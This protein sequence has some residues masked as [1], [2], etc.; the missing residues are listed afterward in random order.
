MR[1]I[2][3]VVREFLFLSLFVF[4]LFPI[5]NAIADPQ[6]E[7][8]ELVDSGLRLLEKDKKSKALEAFSQAIKLH[9]TASM[10]YVYRGRIHIE[11]KDL[12]AAGDD[13]NSALKNDSGNMSAYMERGNLYNASR[14]YKYAVNDY[15]VLIKRGTKEM[16]ALALGLRGNIYIEIDEQK[17]AIEDFTQLIELE[18]TKEVGYFGRAVVFDNMDDPLNA[19]EDYNRAIEINPLNVEALNR[20]AD[21][22]DYIG[23]RAS[24]RADRVRAR[25]ILN[26]S[27]DKKKKTGFN[28]VDSTWLSK[29]SA[30]ESSAIKSV[31][32]FRAALMFTNNPD[33]FF[34]QLK[35]GAYIA[36]ETEATRDKP[37]VAVL[38]FNGCLADRAGSCN[39]GVELEMFNPDGTLAVNFSENDLLI[40]GRDFTG[41]HT[42]VITI[43][44]AAEAGD[45][46]G[47]YQVKVKVI[48]ENGDKTLNL[49]QTF[50]LVGEAKATAKPVTKPK[51]EVAKAPAPTPS[52]PEESMKKAEEPVAPVAVESGW[53][54][55][56]RTTDGT[57]HS[58]DIAGIDK[59]TDS[60]RR[61]RVKKEMGEM[62]KGYMALYK[63]AL[64]KRG[65]DTDKFNYTIVKYEVDCSKNTLRTVGFSD[66][67]ATGEI[68]FERGSMESSPKTPKARSMDSIIVNY[69]CR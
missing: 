3:K 37:I 55:I 67:S 63:A 26:P 58:M 10:P 32:G 56:A 1:I 21:I 8:S 47:T 17:K 22:H 2:C 30:T 29:N 35:E 28:P 14:M 51:E 34:S 69:T 13:F 59:V 19:L 40:E 18:P 24:G 31:D 15:S 60:L 5:G 16:K 52:A 27:T 45:P 54:H 50:D 49:E 11:N 43:A 68:L 53:K 38:F 23:D 39:Y 65:V 41:V 4:L 12:K 42:D 62:K 44:M 66:H 48:D 25:D 57:R 6:L 46:N 36:T 7:A 64:R 33:E 9:P 20:R 61:V